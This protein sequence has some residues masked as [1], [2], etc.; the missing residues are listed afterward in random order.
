[1]RRQPTAPRDQPHLSTTTEWLQEHHTG[2]VLPCPSVSSWF[3]KL[4]AAVHL[5]GSQSHRTCGDAGSD[6]DD[7]FY[8]HPTDGR[9]LGQTGLLEK[10]SRPANVHGHELKVAGLIRPFSIRIQSA[11]RM[12]V[13]AT[14]RSVMDPTAA[15][16][17]I[18]RKG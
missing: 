17:G 6:G 11:L 1:M 7:T 13:A 8:H 12:S 9:P 15:F 2:Q 18:V 10:S 3:R 14:S 5:E 16:A 4:D